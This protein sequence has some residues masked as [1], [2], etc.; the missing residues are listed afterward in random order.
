MYAA[1]AFPRLV[2]MLVV[3]LV[4]LALESLVLCRDAFARCEPNVLATVL[5]VARRLRLGVRRAVTLA[6][7][8]PALRPASLL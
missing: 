3:T 1:G 4:G 6:A 7:S 2:V 5:T 8:R